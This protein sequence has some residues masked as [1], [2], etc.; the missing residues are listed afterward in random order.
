MTQEA[1]RGLR[2]CL[3]FRPRT[4]PEPERRRLF[5]LDVNTGDLVLL[6]SDGPC[7]LVPDEGIF[8][9]L[10]RRGLSEAER[11]RLL[12]DLANAAGGEDNITALLV[13]VG[14]APAPASVGAVREGT[15]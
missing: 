5:A 10:N 9:V 11:C 12:V 7:S 13:G 8:A 4:R 6:C 3:P 14:P 1:D 2:R 15:A